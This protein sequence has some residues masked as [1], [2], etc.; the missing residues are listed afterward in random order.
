MSWEDCQEFVRRL[1]AIDGPWRY[2]LPT[3]AQ[4]ERAA[5]AGT[6]RLLGVRKGRKGIEPSDRRRLAKQTWSREYTVAVGAPHPQAVGSREAN[7]WGLHDMAGNVL[8]WRRDKCDSKGGRWYWRDLKEVVDPTGLSRSD[9]R[10]CRGKSFYRPLD[11]MLS[12]SMCAH[13]VDYRSFET[14]FRLVRTRR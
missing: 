5:R 3:K 1:N 8:E 2:A 13:K 11:A 6:G 10:S 14:G 12:Y 9:Y 4:W 7:P